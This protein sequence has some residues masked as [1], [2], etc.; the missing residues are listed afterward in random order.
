M[1]PVKEAGWQYDLRNRSDV[2]TQTDD[3]TFPCHS[4]AASDQIIVVVCKCV[5]TVCARMLGFDQY[6]ILLPKLSFWIILLEFFVDVK[7]LPRGI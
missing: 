3:I 5:C 6:V 7:K 4:K 2:S 1:L